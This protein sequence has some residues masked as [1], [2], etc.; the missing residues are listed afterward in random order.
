M[1]SIIKTD[2]EARVTM[3]QRNIFTLKCEY[4]YIHGRLRS[5][6][7]NEDMNFPVIGDYVDIT[8]NDKGDSIINSLHER[9]SYFSRVDRNGHAEGY[10]KTVREQVLAAN[11]DYVFIV[12]SLNHDFNLNRLARYISTGLQ[13]GA[14]PIVVLTKADLC[15]DVDK[16]IGQVHE[17]SDK[18]NVIAV[19]AVTGQGM[20]QLSE[21]L[22]T[23]NTVVFLGSSGVG[24]STLTNAITGE[25]LMKVNGIREKDSRGHHTTTHKQLIETSS[26]VSVI[27]TPGIRELGMW[28]VDEGIEDT[29]EDITELTHQ[30]RFSNCRHE[31]EP[32]CAVKAALENGTLTKQKWK[33]YKNLK[34]DNQWGISRSADRSRRY[35]GR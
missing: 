28:D 14:T 15:K 8:Y 4:G 29:F 2:I 24:K 31:S 21:Y 18:V 3:V 6:F 19:S 30:C 17:L 5:K 11:F 26:G 23:G 1:S 32:G 7:F 9:Y 25:E 10:A 33:I 12:A 27:D 22:K 20:E 34:R 35:T 16:Y 13:S